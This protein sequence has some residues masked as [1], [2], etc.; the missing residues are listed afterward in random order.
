MVSGALN[1]TP[2]VGFPKRYG[3]TQGTSA[4]AIEKKGCR[5]SHRVRAR[6][7]TFGK[8]PEKNSLLM[9][10]SAAIPNQENSGC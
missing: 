7:D 6:K 5:A 4:I 9:I 10:L 2:L 8:I 1:S 3:T